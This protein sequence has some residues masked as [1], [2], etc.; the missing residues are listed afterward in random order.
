M[1]LELLKRSPKARML[2][3]GSFGAAYRVG[4]VTALKLANDAVAAARARAEDAP[5]DEVLEVITDVSKHAGGAAAL[6][7]VLAGSSVAE[8]CAQSLVGGE[9]VV[10]VSGVQIIETLTVPGLWVGFSMPLA[11]TTMRALFTSTQQTSAVTRSAVHDVVAALAA[12]H[13]RGILHLDVKP[14]NVLCFEDGCKLADFGLARFMG[15]G[16][17]DVALH[18]S[19]EVQTVW[20]RAPELLLLE[21]DPADT[22]RLSLRC[23]GPAADMWSVGVLTLDACAGR[24]VLRGWGTVGEVLAFWRALLGDLTAPR[25]ERQRRLGAKWGLCDDAADFCAQLLDP[26]PRTRMTAREALEHPFLRSSSSRRRQQ[27]APPPPPL[28]PRM[29]CPAYADLPFED[30][31]WDNVLERMARTAHS[32]RAVRLL[33]HAVELLMRFSAAPEGGAQLQTLEDL[34]VHGI[35]CMCLVAKAFSVYDLVPECFSTLR[36]SDAA[37]C[38]AMVR[39]LHVAELRI[40]VA[41]QGRVLQSPHTDHEDLD[42][43]NDTGGVLP[44]PR[45]A[46]AAQQQKQHRRFLLLGACTSVQLFADMGGVEELNNAVARITASPRAAGGAYVVESSADLRLVHAAAASPAWGWSPAPLGA[47]FPPPHAAGAACLKRKRA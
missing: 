29:P 28:I 9:H 33:A 8:M 32:M 12:C 34:Q 39:A 1:L 21:E 40:L 14:D 24:A 37:C 23:V 31:H 26:D 47:C 13:E 11:V 25:E 17:R 16:M 41:V 10:R 19:E 6:K 7:T 30:A 18:A 22:A 2:A 36:G 38:A 20:Y 43:D 27:Q 5:D 4:D 42:D 15:R 45:D 3:A 44:S 46:A 35:A